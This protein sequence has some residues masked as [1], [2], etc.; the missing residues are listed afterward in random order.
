MKTPKIPDYSHISQI[1]WARLAAWIDGEGCFTI[2]NMNQADPRKQRSARIVV[3]QS[4]PRLINWLV[5]NWGG[6]VHKFMGVNMHCFN[7]T[8]TGYGVDEIIK[9]TRP[10]F[11]IKGEQADII[12]AYR[13]TM[14][15]NKISGDRGRKIPDTVLKVRQ[16]LEGRM[17]A[18]KPRKSGAAASRMVHSVQ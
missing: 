11:I 8:M 18:L 5:S 3:S 17:R 7:W 16:E 15:W 12:L 14:G 4:D 9:H 10:F 13:A 1:D 2:A 6:H